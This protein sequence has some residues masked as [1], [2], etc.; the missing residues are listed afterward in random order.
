MQIGACA[1]FLGSAAAGY[2]AA[3]LP[4]SAAYLLRYKWLLGQRMPLMYF[5]ATRSPRK[6]QLVRL[7]K[8]VSID[9]NAIRDAYA[10]GPGIP[11]PQPAGLTLGRP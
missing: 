3:S 5:A 4:I 8:Q 7:R 6:A 1:Y 11:P 2:Y 9:L 10:G